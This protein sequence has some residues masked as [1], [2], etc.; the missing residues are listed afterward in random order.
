MT[1]LSGT[2]KRIVFQNSENGYSILRTN[3]GKT[4]CGVLLYTGTN[5]KDA[6]F[7]AKGSWTKHKTY[8]LQFQFDEFT[9]EE[10][11][12]FYFLCRI[13]KG[14]GRKLAR[15]LLDRYEEK[16]L[17]N[18]LDTSPEDL[19]A[20]KGI[21]EKKLAR[22]TESWVQF[23]EL[24]KLSDI[25]IPHG[26]TQA[27]LIRVFQHFRNNP[28]ITEKLKV[29]PYLLTEVRGIGFKTADDLARGMGIAPDSIYRIRSG[30]EYVLRDYTEREGNSAIVENT[31]FKLVREQLYYEDE[32]GAKIP[33]ELFSTALAEEIGEKRIV[34]LGQEKL[35]SSFLYR[36]ETSILETA[37]S[38]GRLRDIKLTKDIEAYI[39]AKEREMGLDFSGK[40]SE[41]IRTVNEGTYFFILCG[42]AGTGKST[43]SKAILDLLSIRHT[44][45]RIICCALS[46]IAADRIRKTSGFDAATIQ[47]LLVRAEK[48]LPYFVILLDEASMVS[49]DLLFRLLSKCREECRII[50][51]GDPAQL[52]PIGAGDPFHDLI[53]VKAAPAVELT[54]IYRQREDQVLS[55][56]AN[57]IREGKVPPDYGRRYADFRFIDISIDN[58]FS[59]AKTL[60]PQEKKKIREA[61]SL[62][63]LEKILKICRYLKPRMDTLFREKKL[64]EYIRSFQL[65]TPIKSGLLGTNNL[66]GRLQD[67]FNPG[68]ESE[69]DL[70]WLRLRSYDRVVHIHNQD[71]DCYDPADFRKKGRQSRSTRQ[72]IFNG[73]LGIVFRINRNNELLWVYYPGDRIVVEYSFTEAGHLL[74]LSYALTIHKTQGSEFATVVIPMS[75]S[76]FI[77]LNS[78]LLY[79]AITRAKEMCIITG[80]SYAFKR[81]C[82]RKEAIIRDTVIGEMADTGVRPAG[83]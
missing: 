57:I 12:L 1:Q 30:I 58:Y 5:L 62:D 56:F 48:K 60:P 47:S 61:N 39:K 55:Y 76:H 26:A 66:N 53:K 43:I 36:A 4:L 83:Q 75:F 38:K 18:I 64:A 2:I 67:I 20:V 24:R 33:R 59:L 74:Q 14:I 15:Q 42:Y 65:I 81:A 80:E 3:D 69:I 9:L 71:M 52:P 78:K 79:T 10:S 28:E 6:E 82:R 7:T 77:M 25:L 51:V 11:D 34:S 21:K 13:V 73:M 49:S 8:G 70:G 17:V 54:K 35:T 68:K 19:L 23:R 29:N 32:Q 37:A 40:Q 27:L 44:R 41:A 46:G 72:R 50:L 31:L 63:I 45:D 22:I 16:R